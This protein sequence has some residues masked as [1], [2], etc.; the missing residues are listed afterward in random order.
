MATQKAAFIEVK[1]GGRKF[2][3]TKLPANTV[4]KISY[5]AVRGQSE[6]QGAIQRVLNQSRIGSIKAFTLAGGDYPN[7]IVLN[8]VSPSN[9]I[10]RSGGTISFLDELDSAQII[11]GQHRVAGI[12]AAID[13]KASIGKVELTVVIYE[14]LSTQECADIFL[15]INTEQKPV[16]RSL[17]FDLYGIA[18]TE[19]VDPAAV[20]ARDIAIFLDEE[21]GSPYESEIKFPGAKTRKGGIALSTAITAIKPLV[22]DKG[23]LEQIGVHALEQQRQIILNL[24]LA[25]YKKY[26]EQWDDKSNAFLYAA[27]FVGS[28]D[29]LRLKLI[30]YCNLQQSFT[31][32]TIS[33]ALNLSADTLILQSEI[34]GF[35]GSSASGKVYERLVEAFK[36][37]KKSTSKFKI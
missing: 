5:A 20:R 25:L 33:D 18:S 23:A 9:P 14:N 32:D 29:F 11:D 27:G 3:L 28:M 7:A 35:G 15:S 4:T 30:P 22:E 26:G 24:F 21:K 2:I 31:I 12:R 19:L 8:W 10:K 6:E 17:V 37:A 34:K 16:P 36:P 1:Q 13:D